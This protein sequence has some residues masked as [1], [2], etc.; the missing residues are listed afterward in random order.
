[1]ETKNEKTKTD[2][3][4]NARE[5]W[6]KLKQ[7]YEPNTGTELLALHKE[8]MSLEQTDIKEDPETFIT[9]LDGLRA[10]MKEEP[11]NKEITDNNFML[12]V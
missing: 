5:V 8:Y 11:F 4:E 3:K 2:T 1:M 9:Y 6:N 7:R 12:H 10:R